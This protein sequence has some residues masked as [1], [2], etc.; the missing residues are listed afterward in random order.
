M[1]SLGLA[2]FISLVAH[3]IYFF[4]VDYFRHDMQ[5]EEFSWSGST[6]YECPVKDAL[7]QRL[8]IIPLYTVFNSPAS[9]WGVT[10]V[11]AAWLVTRRLSVVK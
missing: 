2:L 7:L 11:G 5:C 6:F 3:F 10:V 4:S 1:S 9:F 8:V